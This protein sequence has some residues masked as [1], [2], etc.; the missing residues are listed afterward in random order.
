[1][2]T[3][4]QQERENAELIAWR[5]DQLAHSGF[6][7]SLAVQLAGDGRYDLHALIE[8]VERGCPPELAV[9]ILAPL[10]TDTA[11][12]AVLLPSTPAS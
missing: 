1:M 5:H 2:A 6:P 8:L 9:R 3:Q 7:N 12:R 11:S 10:D 4:V